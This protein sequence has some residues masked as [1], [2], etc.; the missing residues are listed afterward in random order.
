MKKV[1]KIAMLVLIA[2]LLSTVGCTKEGKQ[3]VAGVNGKNG[4]ANVQTTILVANNASNWMW[5]SG[6]S[7]RQ[8]SW[9]GINQLS[10]TN[11]SSGAVMLY[12]E[13]GGGGYLPLPVTIKYNGKIESNWFTFGTGSLT[14]VVQNTDNSDPIANIPLP[15]RYKLVVIPSA[16]RRANP[17]VDLMN[18]QEV[19]SFYQLKD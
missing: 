9:S 2:G 10:L 14:V 13:D 15:A 5:N 18:Y 6:G 4:N 19:K 17:E 12:Q 3:G 8:A 11:I 1:T 7:W 16:A